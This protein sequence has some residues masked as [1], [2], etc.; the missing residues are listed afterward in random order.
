MKRTPTPTSHSAGQGDDP[1]AQGRRAARFPFVCLLLVL[2][3]LPAAARITLEKGSYLERVFRDGE[4]LEFS[5]SWLGIVGGNAVMTVTPEGDQF[6]IHSLARSQGTLGRIYP[7]R[8]EISSVVNR[9]DFSTLS[10][11]KDLNE[12]GKSRSE[13]TVLDPKKKMVTR[14]GKQFPYEPPILDPLSTVFFVRTLDLSPGKRHRLTMIADDEIYTLDVVVVKRETLNVEGT[15]YET[16]LVEPKMVKG[17]VFGGENQRLLIWFTDD[18]RRVP[19]RIRSELE[20]GSITATLRSSSLLE[21][22]AA[23]AAN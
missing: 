15:A 16:V 3:A 8:D 21:P 12:R 19:V 1:R 23:T 18:E 11:Q 6:R 17:G 10:F 13:L 2:A 5:L 22:K 9:A 20:F 7:V 14:K 4:R